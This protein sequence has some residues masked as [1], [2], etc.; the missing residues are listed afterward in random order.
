[1]IQTTKQKTQT[2]FVEPK[3][4]LVRKDQ[5]TGELSSQ[6]FMFDEEKEPFDLSKVLQAHTEILNYHSPS[7]NM[8][9]IYTGLQWEERV[10]LMARQRADQLGLPY[11]FVDENANHFEPFDAVFREPASGKV[12]AVFY[13]LRNNA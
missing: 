11:V 1:M 10:G 8:G 2:K 7:Q 13:D 5:E 12:F 6:R 9:G 3:A 4:L